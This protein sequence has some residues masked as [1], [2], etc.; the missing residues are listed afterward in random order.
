M[1]LVADAYTQIDLQPYRHFTVESL[2]EI[3]Q[4]WGVRYTRA[5]LKDELLKRI[6]EE[7]DRRSTSKCGISPR[8]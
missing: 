8:R 5:V 1:P 6:A 2:R 7:A 4:D 3:A